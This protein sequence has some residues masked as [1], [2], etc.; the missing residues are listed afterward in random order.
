MVTHDNQLAEKCQRVLRMEAG[1]LAEA[2]R[3]VA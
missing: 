3:D 1:K 2:T